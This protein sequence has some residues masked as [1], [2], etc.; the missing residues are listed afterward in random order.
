LALLAQLQT[1]HPDCQVNCITADA[2]SGTAPFGDGASAIFG[3]VQ[4]ISH[5]R[6]NQKGRLHQREQNVRD[7][8]ATHP[9]TPHT[10][11]IRGGHEV[12]ARG[13]SAG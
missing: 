11:R 2:L 5:I 4:V 7:Y 12:V 3:G 6:S 1:Q 9:G 13:G 8:C 10:I